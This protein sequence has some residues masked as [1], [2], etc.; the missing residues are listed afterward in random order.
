MNLIHFLERVDAMATQYP[1][2][3]LRTFIHEIGRA[4]PESEREDFL[5]RLKAAGEK[6]EKEPKKEAAK[7]PARDAE[8][9]QA[10][11][12]QYQRIRNHLKT[13]DSQEIALEGVWNDEYDDWYGD[14]REWT[15]QDNDGISDMLAEACAFVHTCLDREQYREGYQI[16]KQL[17]SM[18]I[19]SFFSKKTP[20]S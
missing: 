13:I 3:Q 20:T 8:G 14:S 16:G 18:E 1:A 9:E 15:Y 5:K 7:E 17:F 10:F 2:E 12:E 4:L 11:Q 19:L 6:T